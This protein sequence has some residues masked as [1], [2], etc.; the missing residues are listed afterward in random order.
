MVIMVV[1]N[2]LKWMLNMINVISVLKIQRKCGNN[3]LKL[4]IVLINLIVMNMNNVTPVL[5]R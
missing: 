5:N 4:L 1:I 2:G 3:V